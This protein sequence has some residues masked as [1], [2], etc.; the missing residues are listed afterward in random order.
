MPCAFWK[1]KDGHLTILTNCPFPSFWVLSF[2]TVQKKSM[3]VSAMCEIY[4]K[5]ILKCMRKR[6][7]KEPETALLRISIVGTGKSIDFYTF[8]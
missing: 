1:V 5:Y 8:I 4:T 2:R 3:S 7:G 6:T